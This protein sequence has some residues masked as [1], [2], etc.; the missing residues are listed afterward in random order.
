M[1]AHS[2]AG[3]HHSPC[4]RPCMKALARRCVCGDPL[5]CGHQRREAAHHSRARQVGCVACVLLAA[6]PAS[7]GL[8]PRFLCSV[9]TPAFPMPILAQAAAEPH[10]PAPMTNPTPAHPNPCF[11]FTAGA[12]PGCRAFLLPQSILT[13]NSKAQPVFP[14]LHCSCPPRLQRLLEACW[15]QEP[16]KRPCAPDIAKA[17]QRVCG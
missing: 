6:S 4:L 11:L 2:K 12:R 8:C 3:A 15:D 16:R 17:R 13:N 7:G 9:Y 5:Q 10:S 14:I 1:C